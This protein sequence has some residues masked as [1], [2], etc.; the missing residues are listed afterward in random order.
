[1]LLEAEGYGR[2][3]NLLPWGSSTAD[4][5]SQTR[6]ESGISDRYI[7]HKPP[8]AFPFHSRIKSCWLFKKITPEKPKSVPTLLA[9]P[10]RG[11]EGSPVSPLLA[12]WALACKSRQSGFLKGPGVNAWTRSIR[13]FMT[14]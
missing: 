4:T 12:W 3:V 13:L 11:R 1:M 10:C 9:F 5:E 2:H 7:C 14:Q 6:L 8:N